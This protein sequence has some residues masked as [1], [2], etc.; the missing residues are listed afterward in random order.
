MAWVLLIDLRQTCFTYSLE[1]LSTMGFDKN[2]P[3]AAGALRAGAEETL[4][5]EEQPCYLLAANASTVEKSDAT[6]FQPTRLH[7]AEQKRE[8]KESLK[9]NHDGRANKSE[10]HGKRLES[11]LWQDAKDC[12]S[13]SQAEL[14]A[15]LT[16]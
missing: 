8:P 6:A 4:A 9:A 7:P 5:H 12:Y 2:S 16:R 11:D 3:K 13:I 1:A 10:T 15:L 14:P